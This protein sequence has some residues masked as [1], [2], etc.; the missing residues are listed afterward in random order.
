M[1]P[2]K[3]PGV[4][5]QCGD[6]G[7][8]NVRTQPDRFPLPNLHDVS[9]H[10]SGKVIFSEID[11]NKTYYQI[12]MES[13]DIPKTAINSPFRLF[14]YART[15][16]GLRNT[17]HTLQR[18][19]DQ[20]TRGLPFVFAYL[21][22]VLVASTGPKEHEQRYYAVYYY[23]APGLSLKPGPGRQSWRDL[24]IFYTFDFKTSARVPGPHKF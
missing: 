11:L 13:A 4:W 1:V 12:L 23:Y 7:A 10:R 3:D 15:P 20:A 8:L 21:D 2:K 9:A 19:I 16:F 6:H 5:L 24:Q 14:E 22:Y 18:F 17:A